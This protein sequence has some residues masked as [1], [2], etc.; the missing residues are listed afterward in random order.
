MNPAA[1]F[2]L[3][4]V[5]LINRDDWILTK[6]LGKEVLHAGCTD[7]ML[8]HSKADKDVLLHKKLSDICPSVTGIDIDRDGINFLK[9]KFG[10]DNIVCGSIESL[11]AI[12]PENTFDVILA[13]DVMEHLNNPG[14]FLQTAEK[15]LKPFGE[16]I[17]TVPNAF[18]FK[19]FLGVLLFRQERNHPDHVCFYSLMNLH[20]LL[21]RYGFDISETYTFTI[22]D[23]NKRK[24]NVLANFVA[25]IIIKLF[26]NANVADEWAIVAKRY[27]DVGNS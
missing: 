22:V 19:K 25:D 27:S 23:P 3:P 9:D 5:S 10:F 26:R 16:L 13:A 8:T 4:R 21:H 14:L 15:V 20:R 11:D 1:P 24:I 2:K 12:F 7:N 18:S 17:I 6:I